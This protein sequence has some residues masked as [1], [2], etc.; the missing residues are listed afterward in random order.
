MTPLFIPVL[1]HCIVHA[2]IHTAVALYLSLNMK[3]SGSGHEKKKTVVATG[4]EKADLGFSGACHMVDTL[5]VVKAMISVLRPDDRCP[6]GVGGHA[7]T[8][9]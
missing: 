8:T 4:L 5:H 3:G 1:S 6:D 2:G 9:A 7:M